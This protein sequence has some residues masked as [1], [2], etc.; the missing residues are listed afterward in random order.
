MSQVLQYT[1]VPITAYDK[2][3]SSYSIATGTL[4]SL[5]V[6]EKTGYPFLVTNRHVLQDAGKIRLTFTEGKDGDPIIGS[7]IDIVISDI[8]DWVTYHP[9][10]LIDVAA[11]PISNAMERVRKDGKDLCTRSISTNMIPGEEMLKEFNAIEDI[12]FIGYPVGIWDKKNL[13][14]VF[15][16][17]ITATSLFVDFD[18]N[19]IFLIDASV[20]P[21]SSGSPVFFYQHGFHVDREG[22]TKLITNRA[23]FLG[24]VAA[25]YLDPASLS[26]S[27]LTSA[28]KT[29]RGQ[30]GQ[31]ANLG[32]VYKASTIV[33]TVKCAVEKFKPANQ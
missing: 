1:T 28:A 4:F 24:I 15:R 29:D 16:R 9:N 8:Q 22:N 6:S 20:F 33:D 5:P 12:I 18:G 32:I 27:L 14:P 21:G 25:C 30:Y 19:P 13:L 7:R 2:D 10:N 3:G 31:P 17:G 23:H 11:L 26:E